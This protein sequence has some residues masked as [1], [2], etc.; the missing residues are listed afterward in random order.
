MEASL[1]CRSQS[2][3][4]GPL[5]LLNIMT[6]NESK[7]WLRVYPDAA[8]SELVGFRDGVLQVRVA[9]PPVRGKA[10]QELIA[11]LSKALAV[12]KGSLSIVKGHTSRS[13]VIAVEGLSQEDIIKRLS[14]KPSSFGDATRQSK[15]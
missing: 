13:K 7:I 4:V 14:P 5:L 15:E 1:Q 10:N 6:A 8:K 11:L 9:A 2:I 3:I 12:G